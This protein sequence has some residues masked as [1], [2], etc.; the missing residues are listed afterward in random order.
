MDA[1]LASRACP[2]HYGLCVSE[3][4]AEYKHSG[5]EAVKD[6]FHGRKIVPEQ[7]IWIVKKGDLIL[8]DEPLKRK[9]GLSCKFSYSQIS[10]NE[11][12]RLTFV[13]TESQEPP[14]R[15]RV[16]PK[17]EYCSSYCGP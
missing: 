17:G 7:L 12:V 10:N 3:S 14:S 16:L 9:F 2:R 4:Y 5:H 8:P 6:Q 13:G 15:L 1:P 11:K